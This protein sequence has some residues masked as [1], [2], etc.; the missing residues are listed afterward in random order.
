MSKR[1]AANAN[2]VRPH[3]GLKD[4]Q[5]RSVVARCSEG[6]KRIA[7]EFLLGRQCLSPGFGSLNRWLLLLGNESSSLALQCIVMVM[8]RLAH[9]LSAS[10]LSK[11]MKEMGQTELV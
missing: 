11:R 8:K 6:K 2:P 1:R 3:D 4:G 10:L 9:A 7:L 5:S